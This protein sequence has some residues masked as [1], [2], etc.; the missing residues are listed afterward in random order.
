M[1]IRESILDIILQ[2]DSSRVAIVYGDKSW[3]YTEL[4][5]RC[6]WWKEHLIN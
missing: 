1:S 5:E 2:H 6:L 4:S 3:T